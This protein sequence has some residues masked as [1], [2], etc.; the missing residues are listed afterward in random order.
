MLFRS[1]LE[2]ILKVKTNNKEKILVAHNRKRITEKDIVDAHK[3]SQKF[4]LPFLVM[5]LGKISK[6]LNE[7]IEAIKVLSDIEIIK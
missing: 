6:K 4:N 5:S 2:L 1:N 7:L 3:K